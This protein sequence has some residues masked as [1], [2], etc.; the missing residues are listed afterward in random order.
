MADEPKRDIRSELE[1][2]HQTVEMERYL[3]VSGTKDKSRCAA[4][5]EGRA[6][7]L[8]PSAWTNFELGTEFHPAGSL[9]GH[10]I[11]VYVDASMAG[12]LDSLLEDEI[13]LQVPVPGLGGVSLRRAPLAISKLP[14]RALRWE[15]HSLWRA[16]CGALSASA[17]LALA[18]AGEAVRAIGFDSLAHAVEAGM[19]IPLAQTSDI[20][21]SLITSTADAYN[22]ILE[23]IMKKK[24]GVEMGHAEE[25]DFDWLSGPGGPVPPV[26]FAECRALVLKRAAGGRVG[27]LGEGR[28]ANDLEL[29]E[30]KMP[31]PLC[32]PINVPDRVLVLAEE[33]DSVDYARLY[34]HE[35]GRGYTYA[36]LDRDLPYELRYMVDPAVP[37]A[38]GYVLD[39]TFLERKLIDSLGEY[40]LRNEWLPVG[41]ALGLARYRADAAFVMALSEEGGGAGLPSACAKTVEQVLGVKSTGPMT[42]RSLGDLLDPIHRMRGL[43]LALALRAHLRDRFGEDWGWDTESGALMLSL[44][45]GGG[46]WTPETLAEALGLSAATPEAIVRE[47]ER[48]L[49]SWQ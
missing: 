9:A 16:S 34:A 35:L 41:V 32:M 14:D 2:L 5:F 4:L 25:H 48:A 40:H 8:D 12:A 10:L 33:R 3:Q 11:H 7:L 49:G 29:R 47:A 45:E 38:W 17:E 15:A 18:A 37:H 31:L 19:G 43:M 42:F 26:P 20:A 30:G 21:A 28:P 39:W 36:L 27:G 1:V 6:N 44:W 24:C 23:W 13:E 22:D 46:S